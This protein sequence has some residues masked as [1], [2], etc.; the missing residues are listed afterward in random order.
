MRDILWSARI[1]SVRKKLTNKPP[2]KPFC[3]GKSV[4]FNAGAGM[5]HDNCVS[6]FANKQI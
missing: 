6:F 3:P 4:L 2:Q 5:V 1:L